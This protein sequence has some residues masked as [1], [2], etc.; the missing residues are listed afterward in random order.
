MSEGCVHLQ[1]RRLLQHVVV[2][3]NMGGSCVHLQKRRLLQ[4]KGLTKKQLSSCVHLQKRR[5][6]QLKVRG[7]SFPLVVFTS[8]NGGFYNKSIS[9]EETDLLCSPPKTEAFTTDIRKGIE[10]H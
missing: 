10:F 6:L 1:K 2:S 3:G 4:Q 7:G 9:I 8:K 5:L